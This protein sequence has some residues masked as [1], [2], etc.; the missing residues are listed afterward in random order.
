VNSANFKGNE[1][2]EN[3]QVDPTKSE[4]PLI[5]GLSVGGVVVIVI[6]LIVISKKRQRGPHEVEA[7]V[8]KI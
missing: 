7:A 2:A 1:D 4:V 8:S 6:A 5:V 3:A